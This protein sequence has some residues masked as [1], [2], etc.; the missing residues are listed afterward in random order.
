MPTT[1][2]SDPD[3]LPPSVETLLKSCP[4]SGS[5]GRGV[6]RWILQTANALR[7]YKPAEKAAEMIEANISRT[8]ELNEIE[9]AIK[10]AY[11]GQSIPKAERQPS[12]EPDLDLIKKIVSERTAGGRSP[13]KELQAASAE[14]PK[15]TKEIIQT[16]FPDPKTFIC[17]GR[18]VRRA[19]CSQLETIK[20]LEKFQFVVPNPMHDSAWVDPD[21]NPHARCNANV[22]RRRYL[23]CDLDIQSSAPGEPAS[24][25]DPLIAEWK[26][27][28]IALSDAQ[29]AVLEQLAAAPGPLVLITF[30]GHQSLQ[31]W[32]FC[33]GESE[34]LNGKMRAFFESAVILGA[35][36]AGWTRCQFFR[37][38]G[39]RRLDTGHQQT[40][41]YLNPSNIVCP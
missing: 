22:L 27:Q 11:N 33:E 21:G 28:G 9:E 25:Y 24:I 3:S 23:I 8:P 17:V 15:T 14:I 34:S 6:H 12:F 10:K 5:G 2:A 36:S 7:H 39:A 35:D 30:S 26:S 18:T 4:Q 16:L 41:Y 31:A 32:F 38:P 40:V 1:Y 37:M 13:L 19:W 29:A 20:D